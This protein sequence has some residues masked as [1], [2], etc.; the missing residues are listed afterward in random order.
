[1]LAAQADVVGCGGNVSGASG[2]VSFTVGQVAAVA[3]TGTS[4]SMQEGVQQAYLNPNTSTQ[5]AVDLPLILGPNPTTGA[6]LLSLGTAPPHP[7]HYLVIDGTG[8]TVLSGGPIGQVTHLSVED[9]AAGTYR[10]L[11][12]DDGPF[13]AFIP[14]V[15]TQ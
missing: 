1:M 8:R 12:H 13:L 6:L 5:E 7:L 4:G 10:L 9:L 3:Y 2:S 11:L 15:K 14:F